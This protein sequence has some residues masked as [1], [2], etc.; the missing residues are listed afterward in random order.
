M[1]DELTLIRKEISTLET[2][3][4]AIQIRRTRRRL[5]GFTHSLLAIKE[6]LV[7]LR[8]K[9]RR[10]SEIT[11]EDTEEKEE[12]KELIETMLFTV[13]E[14]E[15][16]VEET[17]TKVLDEDV[18]NLRSVF[19]ELS[20]SLPIEKIMFLI[21]LSNTPQS[22]REELRLDFE[23]VRICYYAGAFRSAIGMCGRILEVILA[24]KYFEER[25]VDPVEQRWLIGTLIRKCFEDEVID[26]PALGDMFN[27]INR[28]RISSVHRTQRLYKPE[29]GITK[30]IIEF[31]I[32]L[33]KKLS[34]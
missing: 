24:R 17:D 25:D 28:S 8:R 26:E 27:L 19:S 20:G 31:T 12:A 4:Q 13:R 10:L 6:N 3:I 2:M 15:N 32:G 7:K 30:S 9:L 16:N 21:D 23:E 33:V 34:N 18:K 11:K 1:I 5:L 22:I 14:R 29:Q